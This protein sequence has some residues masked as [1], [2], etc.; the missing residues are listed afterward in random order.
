MQTVT[1]ESAESVPD[2]QEEGFQAHLRTTTYD[3]YNLRRE[4]KKMMKK[5]H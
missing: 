4:T 3:E 2:I 5:T 1:Q